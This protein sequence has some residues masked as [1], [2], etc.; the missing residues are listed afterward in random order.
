MKELK[1]LKE[2]GINVQ[3]FT[4]G[5][6]EIV[7]ENDGYISGSLA[8]KVVIRIA[9]PRDSKFH[10][11]GVDGK[12]NVTLSKDRSEGN[13][14]SRICQVVV[15]VEWSE[16]YQVFCTRFP[17]NNIRI[18]QIENDGYI[19][20]WRISLISQNG[21][22]FL[23]AEITHG[24]NCYRDNC[25]AICPDLKWESLDRILNKVMP[26]NM[27]DRLPDVEDIE[28]YVPSPEVAKESVGKAY[29]PGTARVIWWSMAEGYGRLI[30]PEGNARVHWKQVSRQDSRLVYLQVG[31]LVSYAELSKPEHVLPRPT[32]FKLEAY[33]VKPL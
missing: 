2:M 6:K 27:V 3:L 33:G 32:T 13:G 23:T 29:A 18:L 14:P 10:A 24:A 19:N 26:T 9:I 31:E 11:F 12:K 25:G 1:A 5:G 28:E 30:T 16:R 21:D 4:E 20:L 22:F 8:D 17:L 7:S 15:P